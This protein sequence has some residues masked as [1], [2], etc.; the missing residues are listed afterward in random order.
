VKRALENKRKRQ[1]A[2]KENF[3]VTTSR[4]QSARVISKK[5]CIRTP[6]AS[7]YSLSAGALDPFDTLAVD[8][9][10]LQMLLGDRKLSPSLLYDFQ[11]G[12]VP[13]VSTLTSIGGFI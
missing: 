5:S 1:Q 4:D 2:S 11:K 8:S 3:R 13:R 9:S 7:P 6:T 12:F 10:R